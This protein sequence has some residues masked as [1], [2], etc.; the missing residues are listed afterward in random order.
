MNSS[1]LG[2]DLWNQ[3]RRRLGKDDEEMISKHGYPASAGADAAEGLIALGVLT[4]LKLQKDHS[5][6]SN[7]ATYWSISTTFAICSI[8]PLLLC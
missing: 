2:R 7:L 8:P 5:S 6:S 3:A 4:G 1:L